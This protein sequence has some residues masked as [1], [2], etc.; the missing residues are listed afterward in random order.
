MIIAIILLVIIISIMTNKKFRLKMI[1]GDYWNLFHILSSVMFTPWMLWKFHQLG[2]IEITPLVLD[3]RMFLSTIFAAVPN[4][5]WE[6][7]DQLNKL[8]I[9]R[10]GLQWEI[11]I[12][13]KFYAGRGIPFLSQRGF[14]VFDI[15]RPLPLALAIACI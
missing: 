13:G 1:E 3:L 15:I 7:L 2:N 6:C 8:L 4:F 10:F 12:D 11:Q 5:L 9:K 14:E